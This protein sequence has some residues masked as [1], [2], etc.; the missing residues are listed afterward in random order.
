MVREMAMIEGDAERVEPKRAETLDGLRNFVHRFEKAAEVCVDPKIETIEVR[1]QF[2]K[3]LDG[4]Y[5]L[6]KKG[7][8][9][10]HNSSVG[11]LG[12]R[13]D[14]DNYRVGI[15]N[16]FFRKRLARES[17]AVGDDGEVSVAHVHDV[18]DVLH[19]VLHDEDFSAIDGDHFPAI[20]RK[21]RFE[22]FVGKGFIVGAVL[23]THHTVDV[24]EFAV[25]N[26][27]IGVGFNGCSFRTGFGYGIGFES[28]DLFA[29]LVAGKLLIKGLLAH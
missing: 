11:G 8:F 10:A 29:V 12:R 3:S 21:L 7:F 19:G 14:R 27:Q 24:T 20:K 23:P 16:Y 13:I 9:R 4:A 6:V 17:A 28:S 15:A 22:S 18:M 1:F 26:L 2:L 5:E 25:L